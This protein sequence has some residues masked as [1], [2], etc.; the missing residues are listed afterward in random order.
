MRFQ[1]PLHH[2]GTDE[3]GFDEMARNFA[4]SSP[5]HTYRDA[6]ILKIFADLMG[7]MRVVV[8]LW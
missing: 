5:A 3:H 2:L 7:E 4:A 1:F 6:S 8:N